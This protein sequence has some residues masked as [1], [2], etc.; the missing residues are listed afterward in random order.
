[1]AKTKGQQPNQKPTGPKKVRLKR[2]KMQIDHD[3]LLISRYRLEGLPMYEIA[4]RLNARPDVEYQLNVANIERDINAVRQVWNKEVMPNMGAFLNER[5]AVQQHAKSELFAMYHRS[6]QKG[7]TMTTQQRAIVN[8]V[9]DADKPS[10]VTASGIQPAMKQVAQPY[11][12]VTK[13]DTEEFRLKVLNAISVVDMRIM[14]IMGKSVDMY[15]QQRQQE[16]EI[17]AQAEK[18]GNPYTVNIVVQDFD[19]SQLQSTEMQ[20]SDIEEV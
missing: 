3:R 10:I 11:E 19:A 8:M 18:G 14:Q 9:E 6:F 12:V 15:H 4:I 16:A 13:N 7:F 1:M 17:Q 20:F 2:N 5:I